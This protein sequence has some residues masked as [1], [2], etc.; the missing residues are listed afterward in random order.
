[1]MEVADDLIPIL[2]ALNDPRFEFYE[3]A[4]DDFHTWP[5]DVTLFVFIRDA[6]APSNE[7]TLECLVPLAVAPTADGK[8]DYKTYWTHYTTVDVISLQ[9]TRPLM[10]QAMCFQA[11]YTIAEI[12]AD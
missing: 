6:P 5:S 9:G 10:D 7:P 11:L 2:T 3:I 8:P 1:M 12:L 4:T